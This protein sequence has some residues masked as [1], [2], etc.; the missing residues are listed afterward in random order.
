MIHAADMWRIYYST[1]SSAA[2]ST[3]QN[4]F[5]CLLLSLQLVFFN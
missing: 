5:R 1:K 4:N 3:V 2:E